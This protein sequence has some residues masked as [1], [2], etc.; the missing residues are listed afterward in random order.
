MDTPRI[1]ILTGPTATGKT[2]LAIE[3]ATRYGADIISAD[4][5]Q[6]YRYLDIGTAKPTAEQQAAVPHHLINVIN[7]DEQFD[8]ARFRTDAHRIIAEASQR[9]KR[10]LVAGGT[11]LYLRA[12]T[13]GLFDGPPANP[14]LRA[15]LE[16]HERTEGKGFLHRW[17]S[18]VDP[19]TAARLHPNDV[20]RQVRALEVFLLTEIPMSRWQQEH[21][22]RERPFPTLLLS[23][24]CDRE[25][26]YR[27]IE[28]R[29]R[30][31]LRDGLVEELRQVWAMGY[32]PA[33]PVFQTIGY[34]QMGAVLQGRL[35]QEDALTQ[36]AT[37]TKRLAKR[38]LTWLRVEPNVRWFAPVQEREMAT[39][40]EKFWQREELKIESAG[41]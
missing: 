33:L 38:Q 25:T 14:P 39:E 12:L 31:M 6:V 5:R 27:R 20:L 21:G 9:G 29:C 19:P 32:D 1:V 30:Q 23:L 7:P 17:L 41:H 34:A 26:L 37:E 2:A 18:R 22:F 8:G 36:M 16:E 28:A 24:M 11:G 40:I 35:G 3:F 4:S 10:I 13:R 15:Q